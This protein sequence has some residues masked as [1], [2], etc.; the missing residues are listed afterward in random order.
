MKKE[1]YHQHENFYKYTGNNKKVSGKKVFEYRCSECG[2]EIWLERMDEA[3]FKYERKE[4]IS[5]DV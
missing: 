3:P 2:K 1:T 4:T 5:W